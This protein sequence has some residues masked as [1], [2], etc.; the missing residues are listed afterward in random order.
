MGVFILFIAPSEISV[1]VVKMVDEP[2]Y[3][4]NIIAFDVMLVARSVCKAGV[5]GYMFTQ[6]FV[7]FTFFVRM[8]FEAL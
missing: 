8:K 6:F 7:V 5:D 4:R 1:Y 3:D 2:F